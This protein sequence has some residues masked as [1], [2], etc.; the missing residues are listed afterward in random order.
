M[1]KPLLAEYAS[2]PCRENFEK[3]YPALKTQFSGHELWKM[4]SKIVLK[5]Q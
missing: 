5:Q 2:H 1:I 4:V 3:I